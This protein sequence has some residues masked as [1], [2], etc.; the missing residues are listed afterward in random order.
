MTP[1]R[2]TA[3]SLSLRED[4]PQ[5]YIDLASYIETKIG[6]RLGDRIVIH[7]APLPG[8]LDNTRT[9]ALGQYTLT[10]QAKSPDAAERTVHCQLGIG[11]KGRLRLRQQR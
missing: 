9:L 8:I 7:V 3:D 11:A 4:E 6:G 2:L 5:K 1:W 10:L